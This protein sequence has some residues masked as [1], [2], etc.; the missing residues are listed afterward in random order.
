NG[1]LTN[2]TTGSAGNSV[3]RDGGRLQLLYTPTSNL[4][5]RFIGE[6]SNEND[7]CCV[8]SIKTVLPGSIA[9]ATARTLTAFGDLGYTP[10]GSLTS[11]GNNSPQDMRTN[12]YALSTEVDW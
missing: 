6:F 1:Y 5:V 3:G 12:Q 10:V 11:V 4:S 7:T 2:T 8:S 9:S